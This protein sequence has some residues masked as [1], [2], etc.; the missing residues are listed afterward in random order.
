[1]KCFSILPM[2]RESNLR[3][4]DHLDGQKFSRLR[5]NPSQIMCL[6]YLQIAIIVKNRKFKFPLISKN[7]NFSPK[8]GNC[9]KKMILFNFRPQKQE[10]LVCMKG[11]SDFV[12]KQSRLIK[13]KKSDFVKKKSTMRRE[14]R[15]LQRKSRILCVLCQEK[16]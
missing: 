9:G 1:M 8:R 2:S 15:T 10:R 14:I 4:R 3:N 5:R 11:L 12:N 13:K 7:R 16:V 6:S